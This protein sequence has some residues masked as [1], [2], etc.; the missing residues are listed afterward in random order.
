MLR[1]EQEEAKKREE[2][3]K[4]LKRQEMRTVSSTERGGEGE[5]RE[6]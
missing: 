2:A 6:R 3:E 5:R 4:A 1:A